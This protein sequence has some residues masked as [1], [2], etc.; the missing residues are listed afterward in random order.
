[1]PGGL[2][3]PLAVI[4]TWPKPNYINPETRPNTVLVLACVWG[5]LTVILVLA[6]LWVRMFHQKA[7]GWDDWLMIAATVRPSSLAPKLKLIIIASYHCSDCY[8][9]YR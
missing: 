4:L 1:M 3:A 7:P 9:C 8:V 6:R 2:H 5:P